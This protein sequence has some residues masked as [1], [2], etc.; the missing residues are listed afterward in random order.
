MSVPSDNAR[1]SLG[2]T[3]RSPS[4]ALVLGLVL[5][6][7]IAVA[8]LQMAALPWF[9]DKGL[10]ALTLA[11]V[12]GML[13]GNTAYPRLEAR[14]G[15]GVA[16]AKTTLLR[17][18]IV[19]YGIRLTFSDVASIGMPGL[20][21]DVLMLSSTWLAAYWLGTRVLHLERETALL[22]GAGSSIC[23]A[24]AVMA[25]Q[26]LVRARA[27]QAIVAVA[28]VVVFGTLAMFLWPVVYRLGAGHGLLPWAARDYGVFVGSTV[29]EV[30]QV[31]VAGRALG[32]EAADA[33]VIVKMVRVMLLAPALLFVAWLLARG[34]SAASTPNQHA[35]IA[36]PWFAFGFIAVIALNSM[37]G[38]PQ[39]WRHLGMAID[40]L[41]L[42][43]AMAALGLT[44][45][46]SML[47]RAGMRP[48]WLASLL[49]GW[50]LGGGLIV[51]QA[52]SQ[53]LR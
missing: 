12:I 26:P 46:V 37:V 40:D 14:V 30:A 4:P 27:E 7:L 52:I 24:A 32:Q 45:H 34:R 39:P 3:A 23:G 47:R 29:H 22:I 8:A 11:I 15:H 38:L 42:A 35:P 1:P 21:I 50:L 48:L 25:A 41:L 9:Q 13:I 33:A 36:V 43:M 10:S 44:T 5:A 53:W 51:N 17:A 2:R 6:A 18:G 49:F 20:L 16:F 31:V 28:M 19:L